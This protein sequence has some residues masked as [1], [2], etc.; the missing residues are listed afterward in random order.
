[1]S[2]PSGLPITG[3]EEIKQVGREHE[4]AGLW[5]E[6]DGWPAVQDDSQTCG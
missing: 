5:N 3:A 1:M 4:D 6:K 2:V